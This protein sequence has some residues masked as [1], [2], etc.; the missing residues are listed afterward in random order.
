MFRFPSPGFKTSTLGVHTAHVKNVWIMSN[1]ES[2]IMLPDL[3]FWQLGVGFPVCTVCSPFLQLSPLRGPDSTDKLSKQVLFF[4]W[5]FTDIRGSSPGSQATCS[6]L[7]DK[8]LLPPSS[9]FQLLKHKGMPKCLIPTETNEGEVLSQVGRWPNG[10]KNNP[11]HSLRCVPLYLSMP[12]RGCPCVICA[13]G[14]Q[15]LS[16]GSQWPVQQSRQPWGLMAQWLGS[17]ISINAF[18]QASADFG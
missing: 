4:M 13:V 15:L 8:K 6:S 2:R 18:T 9:I 12:H 5:S 16:S 17:S 1:S 14:C 10:I 7:H 3:Q 11:F